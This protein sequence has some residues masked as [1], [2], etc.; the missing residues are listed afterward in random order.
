[1]R[2][3]GIEQQGLGVEGWKLVERARPEPGPAQVLVRVHAASLNYRDLMIA[4]GPYGAPLKPDLVP[5]SDGAGEV[6]ALAP[7]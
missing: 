4:K 6:V 5:L 3:V 1:M 2:A 7:A